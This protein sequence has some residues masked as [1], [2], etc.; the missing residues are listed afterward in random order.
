[1]LF[2]IKD[3]HKT[4]ILP[5]ALKC[6][7]CLNSLFLAKHDNFGKK[8]FGFWIKKFGHLKNPSPGL[9]IDREK[10]KTNRYSIFCWKSREI[11]ILY[12]TS[13]E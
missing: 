1:L 11:S 2:N 6:S 7:H 3:A 5:F 12:Q 10:V 4:L 13:K 9:E 8:N